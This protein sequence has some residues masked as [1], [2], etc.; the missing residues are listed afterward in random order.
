MQEFDALMRSLSRAAEPDRIVRADL[1]HI[2]AIT[3]MRVRQ[4]VEHWTRTLG[5][6]F[7]VYAAHYREVTASYLR[8]RLNHSLF[9]VIK[10]VDNEPVAMCAL[11]EQ[12]E[13]PPITVCVENKRHGW[14]VS[15][16]TMPEHRGRGYQQ[17]L[18]QELLQMARERGFG[19]VTLT[20]NRPDAIHVYEKAGFRHVSDKYFL[21]L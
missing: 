8:R 10:Y 21:K 2:E 17:A 7:S 14:V 4:Q 18:M 9:Y 16:Y 20:T 15:V 13:L 11:E 6:D 12:D 1:S 19:D 5:E 3:D